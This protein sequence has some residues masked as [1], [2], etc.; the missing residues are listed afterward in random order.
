M[1]FNFEEKHKHMKLGDIIFTPKDNNY[2]FI[3]WEFIETKYKYR[4]V[5]LNEKRVLRRVFEKIE[6]IVED[7]IKDEEYKVIRNQDIILSN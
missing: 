4:L 3:T 1:K 7:Y 2:Y 5:C 6:D